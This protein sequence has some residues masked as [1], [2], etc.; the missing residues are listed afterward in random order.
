M[1]SGIWDCADAASRKQLAI[2][3]RMVFKGPL[4]LETKNFPIPARPDRRGAG[5]HVSFANGVGRGR[6]IRRRGKP[7]LYTDDC[8]A[9]AYMRWKAWTP[10]SRFTLKRPRW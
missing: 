1:G 4:L 3:V 5:P 7:R 8:I 10:F 2:M 9:L 6:A